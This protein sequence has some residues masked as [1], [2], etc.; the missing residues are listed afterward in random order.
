MAEKVK[1]PAIEPGLFDANPQGSL[2]HYRGVEE[3][4]LKI[5]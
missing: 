4:G 1:R 3:G 5:E 2:W